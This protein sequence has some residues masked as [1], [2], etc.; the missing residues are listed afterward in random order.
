MERPEKDIVTASV[1]SFHAIWGDKEANLRRIVGY[2]EAAARRGSDIVV[3]PEMALTGYDPE[4][5]LP[6]EKKMP[7]RQAEPLDGDAVRAL[8]DTAR[9]QRIFLMVGMP[10]ADAPGTVSNALVVATPDGEALIY[11][12]LHLPDPEPTWATRGDEPV[13]VPTPWGPV[14]VGICYDSYRFP[15]LA[16]Y[17]AARGCRVYVNAT[18]HALVHGRELADKAL[19]VTAIQNGIFVMSANLCGRDLVNDFYGGAAIIGPSQK[20]AECYYYAGVPFLDEQA[21]EE[22][23]DTATIDLALANRSIYQP[24]TACDGASDWR[25][26]LY[27]RMLDDVLAE[28][29]AA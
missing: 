19:E 25:C 1:V 23:M 14:G 7:V 17:Y 8:R 15:E 3:F 13:I 10:I 26:E 18:A 6:W 12:K 4:P 27:R 22:A 28:G 11:R 29:D 20:T 16:R 21:N 2:A 24:R 9:A 5:D